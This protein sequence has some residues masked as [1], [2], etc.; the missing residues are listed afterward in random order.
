MTAEST[1]LWRLCGR[2]GRHAECHLLPLGTGDCQLFVLYNGVETAVE[3]YATASQA[4]WRAQ[5]LMAGLHASG[6]Q[7]TPD[8]ANRPDGCEERDG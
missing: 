4:H 7:R 1:L 8:E 3:V 2:T 5:Q 6:W